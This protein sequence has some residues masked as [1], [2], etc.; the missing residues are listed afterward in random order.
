MSTLELTEIYGLLASAQVKQK[1][2]WSYKFVE[3]WLI[4][5]SAMSTK[6]DLKARLVVLKLPPY[7]IVEELLVV[8]PHSLFSPSPTLT[9]RIPFVEISSIKHMYAITNCILHTFFAQLN[10]L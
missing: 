1:L 9:P 5:V 6:P 2:F 10:I 3:V 7:E 8:P 4:L